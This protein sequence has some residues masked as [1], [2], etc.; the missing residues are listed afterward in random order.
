M[1]D[2]P[3]SL[4]TISAA[5]VLN[6]VCSTAMGI[7]ISQYQVGHCSLASMA[8]TTTI[9]PISICCNSTIT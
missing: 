9:M 4:A 3:P 6:I 1:R 8:M 5:P 2:A 7:S